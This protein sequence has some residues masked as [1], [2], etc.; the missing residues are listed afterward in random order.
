MTSKTI[1]LDRMDSDAIC[2][3]Y[4]AMECIPCWLYWDEHTNEFTVVARQEDMAYVEEV[5]A[6]YV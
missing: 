6:Q 2:A 5:L 4:T 3:I 1:Y